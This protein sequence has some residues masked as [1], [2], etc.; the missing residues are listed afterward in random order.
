MK[1][2]DEQIS[3]REVREEQA[4]RPHPVIGHEVDEAGNRVAFMT[5]GTEHNFEVIVCPTCGF[6]SNKN[7]FVVQNGPNIGFACCPFVQKTFDEKHVG[8]ISRP[9]P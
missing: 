3:D 2:W 8:S 9:H 5:M 7:I 1:R 4:R 6:H